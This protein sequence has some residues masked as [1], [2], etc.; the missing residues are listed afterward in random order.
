MKTA[1]MTIIMHFPAFVSDKDGNYER[2]TAILRALDGYRPSSELAE[3][4]PESF[5]EQGLQ[6]G[7]TQLRYDPDGEF[8]S[9]DVT[10]SFPRRLDDDELAA[11]QKA[12]EA[13]LL[14]GT[15]GD[16]IPVGEGKVWV[17]YCAMGLDELIWSEQRDD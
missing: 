6:G 9:T 3:F 12:T 11:L 16:D 4:M 17:S 14:D 13:Q 8:V 2:D 5:R 1:A 15:T 10:Y 7:S